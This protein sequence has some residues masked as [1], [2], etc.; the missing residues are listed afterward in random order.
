MSTK[1]VA[2]M[3]E[4]KASRLTFGHV[5]LIVLFSMFVLISFDNMHLSTYVWKLS[6]YP[7][8]FISWRIN[9]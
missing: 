2:C 9:F 3:T 7:M 6:F 8:L 4:K 1:S 5:E